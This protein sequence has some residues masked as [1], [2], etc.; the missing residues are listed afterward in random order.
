[1]TSESRRSVDLPPSSIYLMFYLKLHYTLE[2]YNKSL[3]RTYGF[4]VTSVDRN[5]DMIAGME[6]ETS[7]RETFVLSNDDRTDRNTLLI[8]KIN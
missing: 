7:E 6:S 3:V 2:N 8:S 1:M 5:S 4:D